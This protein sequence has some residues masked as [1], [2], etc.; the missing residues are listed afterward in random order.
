MWGDWIDRLWRAGLTAA[1]QVLRIYWFLARPNTQGVYVAVWQGG[2]VLVIRNSYRSPLS[3]PG[4]AVGRGEDAACAAAREL[5]E[6]VGISVDARRLQFVE[7]Y[8]VHEDYH[9]D[10]ASFF[11]LELDREPLLSIDRR[12]VVWAEFRYPEE[13]LAGSIVTPVR[14]Y[15]QRDPH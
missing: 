15:L 7:R 10:R 4:G 11:E 3:L 8:V 13:V 6:E 1:Y 9:D 5:R 12:E 2:R 14:R